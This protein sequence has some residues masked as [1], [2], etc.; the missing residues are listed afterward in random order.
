MHQRSTSRRTRAKNTVKRRVAR[1]SSRPHR[2]PKKGGGL[3]KSKPKAPIRKVTSQLDMDHFLMSPSSVVK[4]E[5]QRALPRDKIS[6]DIDQI[7]LAP[8]A[9]VSGRW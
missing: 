7:F 3:F 6:K 9:K 4:P 5:M 1:S 8:P 2:N